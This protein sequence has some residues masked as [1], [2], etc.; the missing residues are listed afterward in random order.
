M[1][2]VVAPRF[3]ESA[4]LVV[5]KATV[6]AVAAVVLLWTM[7]GAMAISAGVLAVVLATVSARLAERMRLRVSAGVFMGA[8]LFGLAFLLSEWVLDSTVVLDG[9]DSRSTLTLSDVLLFGL[10]IF[11]VVFA[12]R[13]AAA[14]SRMASIIEAGL[15]VGAVAHLFAR[16]RNLKINRPRFLTDWALVNG[17]DPQVI[18]LA[19]GVAAAAVAVLMALRRQRVSKLVLSLVALL[20]LAAGVYW[21]VRDQRV[22]IE[23]KTDLGLTQGEQDRANKGDEEGGKGDSDGK[24]KG[25]G[26]GGSGGSPPPPPAPVALAIF[27]DDYEPPNGVLYF[28]QQVQSKFDGTRLVADAAHHF[29]TDVITQFPLDV[30]LAADDTQVES[31]HRRVPTSMF[32]MVDHPQ[33]LALT[34]SLEIA[35]RQN[36]APRRFVA[37]YT[38]VSLAMET[39]FERLIGRPS[40]PLDWSPEKRAFY[41][42]HADDPRYEALADQ[43]VRELDPR[44]AGDD[45]MKA[46]VIKRWLEVEGFYTRK[47][48]HANTPDPTADFLFGNRRG[49]CVHFAHAAANL[50][51]SQGIAARVAIGYAVDNRMRGGGSAVLI[52]GDRA[53]AWPEIHLEGVGWIPFDIYPERSD[54]PPPSFI[55]QSLES[56]LGELARD[57]PTGGLG[58]P[59]TEP[60]RVPWAAILLV[61]GW[62]LGGLLLLAYTVKTV[63]VLAP[64]A[65]DHRRRFRATLDRFSDAGQ[66]RRWGETR[67]RYAARLAP[68]APS[69]IPLTRAHLR[70][71][72]GPADPVD[73]DVV[74]AL[75]KATVAEFGASRTGWQRLLGWLNPVGWWFTR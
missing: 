63:R 39:P 60:F 12:V 15:V 9:L 8:A 74:D 23:V 66:P 40:V 25:D 56:L 14:R 13:L 51:R 69:L 67:A 57:D 27:H 22:E 17:L 61:L 59:D 24:S 42:A 36:P 46:L 20:V 21:W 32:L 31:F 54:E 43:L 19:I 49:Y 35:A 47:E 37:T 30:P 38:A 5:A 52:L 64:G 28:R 16:H 33:P 3:T 18:L 72:L 26:D 55:D 71:T 1:M 50:F 73:N 34:A 10:S 6:L 68:R 48:R 70:L 2:D 7:A 44:F 58:D 65:G 62:G 4:T 53:H 41:L 45:L 29:D 75:S 11:G